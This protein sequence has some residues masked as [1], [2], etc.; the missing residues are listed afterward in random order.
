[1]A[2]TIWIIADGSVGFNLGT[3]EI[4]CA[5]VNG[6]GL[7]AFKNPAFIKRDFYTCV[8]TGQCS[9]GGDTMDEVKLVGENYARKHG[10]SAADRRLNKKQFYALVNNSERL[11]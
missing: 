6:V 3:T 4:H 2:D 11:Y 9:L 1:M 8:V 5:Y 7:F 10:V